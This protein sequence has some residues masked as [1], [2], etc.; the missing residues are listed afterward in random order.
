MVKSFYHIKVKSFYHIMVNC[1]TLVLLCHTFTYN[2]KQSCFTF[3]GNYPLPPEGNQ[4]LPLF[5]YLPSVYLL[6]TYHLP[7]VYLHLV[8]LQI[9]D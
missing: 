2:G 5:A 3:L 6:Y 1:H 4:C 9:M 7:T 8:K